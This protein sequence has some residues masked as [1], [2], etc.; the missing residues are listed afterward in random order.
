MEAWRYKAACFGL[1]PSLFFPDELDDDNQG[2]EAKG[3]CESCPVRVPCLE[4]SIANNIEHGIWGG[5]GNDLRMWLRARWLS[6]NVMEYRLSIDRVVSGDMTDSEPIA[7][8]CSRCDA[9]VP[10]GDWPIDRNGPN[11]TCGLSSTYNKGCRCTRC[12]EGKSAY[13]KAQRKNNLA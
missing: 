1:P 11:A 10:P 13:R 9:M 8:K 12:S 6:G 4:Y 5:V 3:V 7:K 2:R